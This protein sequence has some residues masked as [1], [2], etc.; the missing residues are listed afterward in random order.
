MFPNQL[1]PDIDTDTNNGDNNRG[2]ATQNLKENGKTHFRNGNYPAA[3]QSFQSA[4]TL[5]T[6]SSSSIGGRTPPSSER[7]V[8]LDLVIQCRLKIG[9]RSMASTAVEECNECI[10]L[11][12][13]RS[14]AYTRLASA[15][16]ALGGHSNDACNALQIA[17]RLNPSNSSVA[18][19][20]LRHQ[21]R[22]DS[23]YTNNGAMPS[24]PPIDDIDDA[25]PPEAETQQQQH[26]QAEEP[27]PFYTDGIDNDD[28][29]Y[30]TTNSTHD[31]YGNYVSNIGNRWLSSLK[32]LLNR[33]MP[34]MRD[35]YNSLS[36][37]FNRTMNIP[38]LRHRFNNLS[39]EWM[40]VL[41]VLIVL[42]VLYIALGG[43]FGLDSIMGSTP[44]QKGN[45]ENGNVYDRYHNK[46]YE[47][48]PRGRQQTHQNTASQQSHNTRYDSMNDDTRYDS[49]YG[50]SYSQYSEPRSSSS[51]RRRSRSQDSHYGSGMMPSFGFEYGSASSMALMMFLVFVL[52]RFRAVGR[53]GAGFGGMDGMG[54]GMGGM[55][56]G[57]GGRWN[58]GGGFGGMMGPMAM[59]G[60]RM[61]MG[62]RRGFGGRRRGGM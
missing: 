39:E 17:I 43:R 20:M 32:E 30:G 1:T 7:E 11:N 45:Y 8:L 59:A 51:S 61:Y 37:E 14:E 38:S 34:P 25:P 16:I 33:M 49:Q 4:L 22:R 18:K 56:A 19:K 58:R 12:D 26:N 44:T 46:E 21:L 53:G 50:G 48:D 54:A 9:G 47:Y 6:I 62:G 60:M 10:L 24:A 41:K 5:H 3:L 31:G 23:E 13:Q 35:R 2:I 36:D 52:N 28:S 40:S 57:M 29:N 55:G 42:L 15:Y 27:E